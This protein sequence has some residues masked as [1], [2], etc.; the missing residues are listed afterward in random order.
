VAAAA[1]VAIVLD[2]VDGWLARRTQMTTSFGAWFDLE[3]DALLI[4]VLAVLAWQFGKAG[5]WVIASGLLRYAFLAAG[6]WW[7]RL[8]RP[9]FASL[10]RQAI[11][12][13]QIAALVVALVP[14]VTPPISNAIAAVALGALC[15]SFAVDT[16]WLWRH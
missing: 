16:E 1:T 11:C 2:G 4:L 10:R 8:R 3:T 5:L 6:W 12:V 13:I 7:V 14:A 9:L 15:Y